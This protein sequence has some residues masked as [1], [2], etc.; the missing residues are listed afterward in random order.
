MFSLLGVFIALF[1]GITGGIV[2]GLIAD[3]TSVRVGLATLAP[4]GILGG[5]LMMRGCTTVD[6]DIAEVQ[7]E[8]LDAP[9]AQILNSL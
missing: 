5:L 3:A 2:V 6:A 4:T 9:L 8:T 7:A 1:G